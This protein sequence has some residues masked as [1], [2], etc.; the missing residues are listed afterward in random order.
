[1]AKTVGFNF[2][3]GARLQSSVASAFDTV[4][5]RTKKLRSDMAA[6]RKTSQLAGAVTA[7][8]ERLATVK[9]EAKAGKA[10]ERQL[11]AAEN[12]YKRAERAAKKYNV[13]IQDSAKVH[14]QANVQM[15]RTE[16]ALKRQAT[17]QRNK[18]K[19]SELRGKVMGTVATAM[20]VA[21]PMHMAIDFE[22]AMADAA[23]TIDGMRDS[24]GRLTPEYYKMEEAVKRMGRTLPLAH[25]EIA[26]IFAAGGQL[27]MTDVAEIEEFT[28]LVAHMSVA[29]GMSTEA[30]A[31]A[32]G[33]Y[34]SQMG[35]SFGEIRE[36]LDLMNQYANTSSATEASISNI[37][38]E[39]GSL[40]ETAGV[41]DKSLTAMAATLAAMK[42]DDSK[43]ATGLSN[44]LL[45]FTGGEAATKRRLNVFN[46]LGID[47][48]ELSKQM[49]VDAE[50]A[51]LNVL[52]KV[53]RLEK[54]KQ[55]TV[56][57]QLFGRESVKALTPLL[58]RLDLLEE[59][60]GKAGDKASYLGAMQEE[61]N[62]RSA[63]TRKAMVLTKN[64]LAEIGITVGT[65]A[66][67][68]LNDTLTV[69][70]NG[71]VAMASFAAENKGLVTTVMGVVTALTILKVVTLAGRYAIT[72]LS[73]A[74]T[75]MR[76]VWAVGK[77]MADRQ[78]Y[79]MIAQTTVSKATAI[80]IRTVAVAQR[81]LNL[82]MSTSPIGWIVKAGMFLG[83][84]LYQLY[85]R[86]A[87]V[88]KAFHAIWDGVMD[89]LEPVTSKVSWLTDKIGKIMSWFSD[90]ADEVDHK[91]DAELAAQSGTVVKSTPV[92]KSPEDFSPGNDPAFDDD[93]GLGDIPTDFPMAPSPD[94]ASLGDLDPAVLQGAMPSVPSATIAPSFT[95]QFDMS[96]IPDKDFGQRVLDS[97]ENKK[98]DI[99]RI[100]SE[101]LND[102]QRRKY[103]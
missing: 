94:M 38:K 30:A 35:K 26:S 25:R 74:W 52:K 90:D 44:F 92:R 9:A 70:G 16:D 99:A 59:N 46:Q 10:T 63:T 37:V 103:A 95:F 28:Q 31:D 43:A 98:S 76:G 65:F 8:R 49:Q 55:A 102:V 32:I 39:V 2:A 12:A 20:S 33:G 100:L 47:S 41:S 86:C 71:A 67:P 50:G 61:Y 101:L 82:L 83:V 80:G 15:K 87:P 22:D 60:F 79:A 23:K 4:A 75:F 97:V 54:Y 68:A 85:K 48:V 57:E 77:V 64:K 42:I 19:R 51:M 62:N 72:G 58:T 29:F 36:M 14:A 13:S 6:L 78:T 56:M 5:G 24:A 3:I 81:A 40:A 53:Q 66:L 93:M 96:G 45:T 27:G 84:V 89:F 18:D 17:Y 88:R 11:I 7:S 1:M 73:D 91:A 21:A 69:V 34:R